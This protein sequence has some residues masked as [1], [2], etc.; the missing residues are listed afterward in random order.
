MNI[1]YA[2]KIN[3]QSSQFFLDFESNH[4]KETDCYNF[5]ILVSSQPNILIL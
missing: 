4:V 2:Y 5:T 1:I 3:D